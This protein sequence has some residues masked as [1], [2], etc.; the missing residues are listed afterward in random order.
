M[1]VTCDVYNAP[2]NLGT[3]GTVFRNDS[4]A[5][6]SRT[7]RTLRPVF[8]QLWSVFDE[9]IKRAGDIPWWYTERSLVGFLTAAAFRA[10]YSAIEEF[11]CPRQHAVPKG[12]ADWWVGSGAEDCQLFAETKQA[13]ISSF[14]NT[15]GSLETCLKDADKQI[16]GYDFGPEYDHVPRL[17]MVFVRAFFKK[18][19]EDWTAQRA[20][21]LAEVPKVADYCAY[22]WLDE[23][24]KTLYK[25][26]DGYSYPGVLIYCKEVQT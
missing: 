20:M 9:Y 17:A 13:W 22:Y 1:T 2:A 12:R 25:G 19:V 18:K 3:C 8:A 26:D 10:G 24:C 21:W 23:H 14:S 5:T 16:Q 15:W 4:M 6:R 11:V 7:Y